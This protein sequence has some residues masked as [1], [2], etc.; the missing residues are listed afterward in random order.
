M[1]VPQDCAN[2]ALPFLM[3]SFSA[4]SALSIAKCAMHIDNKSSK[5]RLLHSIVNSMIPE[6]RKEEIAKIGKEK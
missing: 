1:N 4:L 2:M 6:E 5:Q 3:T